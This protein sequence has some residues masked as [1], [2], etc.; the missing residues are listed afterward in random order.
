MHVKIK[1]VIGHAFLF[2]SSF[3][4]HEMVKFV[5]TSSNF[6]DV[7]W[8]MMILSVVKYTNNVSWHVFTTCERKSDTKQHLKL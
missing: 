1:G 4:G 3:K 6:Q 7:F 2:S 5:G 8:L